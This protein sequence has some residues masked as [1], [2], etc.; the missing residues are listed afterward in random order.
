M[1]AKRVLATRVAQMMGRKFEEADWSF[2]YCT[3]KNIPEQKWSNLHIDVMHSGLGVE[4]KMLC[5]GEGKPLM[6]YAGTTQMHPS[7]T[8]SIRIVSTDVQP[9]VAMR[10]K[11][12]RTG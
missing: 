5:V 11:A 4:Q 10:Y 2:A 12:G 6:S 1:L 8:R 7:A 3:A 9:E